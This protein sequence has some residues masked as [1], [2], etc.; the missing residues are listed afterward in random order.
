MSQR[1]TPDD[2]Q[3]R[4][5]GPPKQATF[6]GY[7]ESVRILDESFRYL[8]QQG[9]HWN[10]AW[11]DI[12]NGNFQLKSWLATA[13]ESVDMQWRFGK[14]LLCGDDAIRNPAPP[15][16]KLEW[17]DTPPSKQSPVLAVSLDAGT[18]LQC[19]Q[20]CPLSPVEG[21]VKGSPAPFATVNKDGSAT[22]TVA[23]DADRVPAGLYISFAF[24]KGDQAAPVLI[25]LMQVKAIAGKGVKP[26]VKP[27]RKP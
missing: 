14:R 12:I 6:P 23:T 2:A 24:Q 21:E 8:K 15:W 18:E 16:V 10:N 5:K 3:K 1:D 17:E 20:F 7:E 13:A 26:G 4:K 27:R 25:I 9:E 19:T 11:T 22:V